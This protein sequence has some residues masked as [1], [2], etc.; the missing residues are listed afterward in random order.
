[1]PLQSTEIYLDISR[2][3][4][5]N[6]IVI[7]GIGCR[8]STGFDRRNVRG[9]VNDRFCVQEARRQFSVVARRA[10][11]NRN[12]AGRAAIRCRIPQSNLERF[13]HGHAVVKRLRD[14]GTHLCYFDR[15]AAG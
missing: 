5:S 8:R 7:S 15:I 6:D 14:A 2:Q 11:R 9:V 3:I 1:M 12:A 10:H 13:L 4:D